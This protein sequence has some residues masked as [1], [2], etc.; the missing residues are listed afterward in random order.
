MNENLPPDIRLQAVVRVTKA[1][2]PHHFKLLATYDILVLYFVHEAVLRIRILMFFGRLD[3]DLLV[4]G[5]VRSRSFCH[6]AKI[7]RKTLIPTVLWLLYE[8]FIFE[9]VNVPVPS[10]SR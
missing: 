4:R 2:P 3:P 6:Q 10:K 1:L 5:M 9:K 8:F 7:V